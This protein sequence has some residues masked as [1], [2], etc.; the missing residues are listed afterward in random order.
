MHPWKRQVHMQQRN[1]LEVLLPGRTHQ[2]TQND[3]TKRH[4]NILACL[5]PFLRL[6]SVLRLL[7]YTTIPDNQYYYSQS[8]AFKHKFWLNNIYVL[9]E[10]NIITVSSQVVINR[11]YVQS[12]KTTQHNKTV[13][14]LMH[15]VNIQISCTTRVSPTAREPKDKIFKKPQHMH[16]QFI[17]RKVNKYK[18][19]Q[20]LAFRL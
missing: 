20:S 13:L 12:Q 8:Y 10:T 11:S 17:W 5:P 19:L 14:S 2:V 15:N 18:C 7:L 3:Y 4:W 6:S 1:L 9:Q 16:N